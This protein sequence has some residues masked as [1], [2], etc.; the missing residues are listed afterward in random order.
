MTTIAE[1]NRSRSNGITVKADYI[2]GITLDGSYYCA[3][4]VAD[5]DADAPNEGY[6]PNPVFATDEHDFTCDKC[7]KCS[8]GLSPMAC[9]MQCRDHR[10]EV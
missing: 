7:F 2:V 5:H 8:N 4:C 1:H 3:D 6:G 9:V 10:T